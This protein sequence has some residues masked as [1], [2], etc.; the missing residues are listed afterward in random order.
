D[1]GIA[2]LRGK[3]PVQRAHE[4]IE[5]CA[6]PEYRPLL[7]EYMNLGNQGQTPISLHSAFAFHEAFAER[8]DMH[9]TDF[10]KYVK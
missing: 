5:N 3:D 6:N 7:R 9:L 4:I 8:G 1:Q 2:D 10:A